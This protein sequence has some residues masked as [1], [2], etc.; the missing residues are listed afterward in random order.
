MTW[1]PAALISAGISVGNTFFVTGLNLSQITFNSNVSYSYFNPVNGYNRGFSLP[2]AVTQAN[3][4][5]WIFTV[6]AIVGSAITFQLDALTSPILY[7]SVVSPPLANQMSYLGDNGITRYISA[8]VSAGSILTWNGTGFVWSAV[9]VSGLNITSSNIGNY[10]PGLTGIG[11]TG[12]WNIGVSGNAVGLFG[13]EANRIPYQTSAN[14]TAF[15]PAPTAAGT[16]LTWNGSVFSWIPGGG[17]GITTSN[18]GNYAPSLAGVGATGTWNI[19]ISG[20]ALEATYAV[21]I[22]GGTLN[23]IPYQTATGVTSWIN[24]PTQANMSLQWNG[25][26]FVWAPLGAISATANIAAGLANELVYQTGVGATGFIVA[27]T[28][29]GTYLEW[30]GTNFVW[31]AV[32]GS[33]SSGALSGGAANQIVYQTGVGI[34]D[35]IVAPTVTS[36]YLEWDG[37][38]FVWGNPAPDLSNVLT[39]SNYGTYAL[40]MS[41]G[42]LTGG[43][44]V[45]GAIVATGDITAFSDERLKKNWRTVTKNFVTKL[46]NVKSGVFDRTDNSLTQVGVSAQSLREIMPEAIKLSFGDTL[47]VNYGGAAMVSAV[48]LAKEVVSLKELVADL[49]KRLAELANIVYQNK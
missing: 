39:T 38:N 3:V 21:N 45:T 40:P 9:G 4:S 34:T 12:T 31:N 24:A 17:G 26:A 22:N 11:A 18:I 14:H 42:T 2:T 8:P 48:E 35:F 13:G 28:A 7:S 20:I 25:S 1:N 46:A 6:K 10:A 49:T 41:G 33:G 44:N 29:S 43:L 32:S 5:T 16:T 19:N 47:S 37:T 30:N 23:E 15:I 36:S 27:P